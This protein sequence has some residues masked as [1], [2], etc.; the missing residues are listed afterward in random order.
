VALPAESAGPR[1]GARGGDDDIHRITTAQTG[2][3][4]EQR[5]RTRRYLISMGI[6]TACFI[7]AV[8]ASGWLR[9]VF[10][11]GALFLPYMAVVMAN[12]GRENDDFTGPE[13]IRP[14]PV[15]PLPPSASRHGPPDS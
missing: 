9:W 3:S 14:I 12:A 10:L 5:A 7:A 8:V 15:A 6:R 11:A 1:R 13:P 2:L 4:Q